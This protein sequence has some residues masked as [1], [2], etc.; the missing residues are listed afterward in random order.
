M[1]QPVFVVHHIDRNQVPAVTITYFTRNWNVRVGDNQMHI[2]WGLRE[3][4]RS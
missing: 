1:N 2:P 3:H 4:C